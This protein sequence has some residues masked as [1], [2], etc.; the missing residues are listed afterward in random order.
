MT[1][2]NL[3]ARAGRWSAS[4]RRTAILG[5]LLFVVERAAVAEWIGPWLMAVPSAFGFRT[6]SDA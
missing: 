2:K 4:H 6:R 3:A 1:S 5:W